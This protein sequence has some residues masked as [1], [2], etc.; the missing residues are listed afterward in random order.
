[1]TP[2]KFE[3]PTAQTPKRQNNVQEY[4]RILSGTLWNI[5]EQQEA[6]EGVQGTCENEM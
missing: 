1:M 2:Q 5:Q 6:P 4:P 3:L